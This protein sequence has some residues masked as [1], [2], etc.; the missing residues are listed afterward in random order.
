VLILIA[1][2]CL[3]ICCGGM[4]ILLGFFKNMVGWLWFFCGE[5]VVKC[6]VKHGQLHHVLRRQKVRHK[7][8]LYFEVPGQ[9]F[10]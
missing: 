8:E 3:F 6:V 4:V 1:V 5:I 9:L 10:F 2:V 7:F